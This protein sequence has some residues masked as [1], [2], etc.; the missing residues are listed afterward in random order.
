MTDM[1]PI[2]DEAATRLAFGLMRSAYL[3]L[4][5]TLR[6]IEKDPANEL[7]RAVEH[8]IVYRL[9][10]AGHD[11]PDGSTQEGALTLAAGRVRSVLREA[12]EV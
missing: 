9:G 7:L 10:S 8:R 3:D 11:C 12:Q 6:S 1:T 4:A 2:A 5:R